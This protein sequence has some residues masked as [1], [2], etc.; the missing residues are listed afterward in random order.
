V[1]EQLRS[2]GVIEALHVQ[3]A[4]F[5]CRA[6]HKNCW[7]DIAI[8][9]KAARR[10][11][12]EKSDIE[13]RLQEALGNLAKELKWPAASEQ[14]ALGSTTVFFKQSAYEILECA[15]LTVQNTAA[16]SIQGTFRRHRM[17]KMFLG[18]RS[19]CCKVQAAVRKYL[20]RCKLWREMTDA[21]KRKTKLFNVQFEDKAEIVQPDEEDEEEDEEDVE[22]KQR[23]LE[24]ERAQEAE[25]LRL[26]MEAEARRIEEAKQGALEEERRRAEMERE[27]VEKQ[28]QEEQKKMQRE[29]EDKIQ[30]LKLEAMNAKEAEAHSRQKY[31]VELERVRHDGDVRKAEIEQQLTLAQLKENEVKSRIAELEEENKKLREKNAADLEAHRSEL[32]DLQ[33]Q[34]RIALAKSVEAQDTIREQYIKQMEE[35]RENL[36]ETHRKQEEEAKTLELDRT[37]RLGGGNTPPRA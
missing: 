26:E 27:R 34:H 13:K 5:P 35:M 2:G 24:E 22:E 25:K 4:G 8:M 7:Q 15:R 33:D 17:Y 14:Y 32:S 10:A 30:E 31:E 16:K 29:F 12:Y 20:Q 28:R 11:E 37:A 18:I 23:Q 21:Q 3:R 1:V 9:F 19:A 6:S 36:D